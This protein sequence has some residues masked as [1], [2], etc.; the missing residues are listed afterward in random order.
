[1]D[2]LKLANKPM[3]TLE[4]IIAASKMGFSCELYLKG[5]SSKDP[6]KVVGVNQLGVWVFSE[7]THAKCHFI[8]KSD[9]SSYKRKRWLYVGHLFG[10]PVI[11]E[12][13]HLF[14][15]KSG[16]L[17]MGYQVEQM[18][19]CALIESIDSYDLKFR[20]TSSK[21]ELEPVFD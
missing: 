3:T 9:L 12:G 19:D 5:E 14:K 4:K 10:E 18:K 21:S 17:W 13:G 11:P 7:H 20:I 1:M 8:K 2:F 16:E 6:W 15:T